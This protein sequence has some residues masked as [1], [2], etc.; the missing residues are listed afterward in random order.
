MKTDRTV[1]KVQMAQP[2]DRD[3]QLAGDQLPGPDGQGEHEVALVAQEVLVEPLDHDDIDEHEERDDEDD[4]EHHGQHGRE[5]GDVVEVEK[6]VVE[7]R[8]E[9]D[10]AEHRQEEPRGGADFVFEQFFQ[11]LNTSRKSASTDMPFSSRI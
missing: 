6:D 9:Q 3:D 4:V 8:K 11:H 10:R 5:V 2:H 7:D 1:T